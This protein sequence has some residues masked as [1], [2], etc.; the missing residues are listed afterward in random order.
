M[1]S[2]FDNPLLLV[3]YNPDVRK[4]LVENLERCSAGGIPCESFLQAED[5]A[6]EV[7]ARESLL[8]CN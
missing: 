4:A 6:R 2:A 3:S 1:N 7:F 8:A 5:V